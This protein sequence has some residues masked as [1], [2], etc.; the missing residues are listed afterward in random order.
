MIYV[1]QIFI[2][3]D[4]T[5]FE[6]FKVYIIAFLRPLTS[7]DG[8]RKETMFIFETIKTQVMCGNYMYSY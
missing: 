2:T 5:R 6:L 7:R 3:G 1:I 4:V 8:I